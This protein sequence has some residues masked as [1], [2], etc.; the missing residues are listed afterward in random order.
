M[1]SIKEGIEEVFVIKTKQ[2]DFFGALVRLKKG[3]VSAQGRVKFDLDK[4]WY[5]HLPTG[6]RAAL[7]HKLHSASHDIA[8]AYHMKVFHQKFEGAIGYDDLVTLLIR[9]PSQKN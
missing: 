9:C 8:D 7:R 3:G 2:I 5:F 1:T 4:Q 6:D